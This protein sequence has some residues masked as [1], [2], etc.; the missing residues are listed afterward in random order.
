MYENHL[1]E[2]TF[3]STLKSFHLPTIDKLFPTILNDYLSG[4]KGGGGGGEL[5]YE[6][7]GDAG[8]HTQGCINYGMDFGLVYDN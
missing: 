5:P 3:Q 1:G 7:G 8:R 6:R 4:R 2:F